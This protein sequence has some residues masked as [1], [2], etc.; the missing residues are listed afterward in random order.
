VNVLENVRTQANA[1]VLSFMMFPLPVWSYNVRVSRS[2][3]LGEQA[4]RPMSVVDDDGS[5]FFGA[6]DID[7]RRRWPDVL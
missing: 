3:E 2:F 6:A 5:Y 1:M 4:V 7:Y